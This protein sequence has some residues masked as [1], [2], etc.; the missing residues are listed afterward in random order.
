[1]RIKTVAM[2]AVFALLFGVSV[3][4]YV[5]LG[6]L[7]SLQINLAE[8]GPT[9]AIAA[10]SL[11][12]S[13][14]AE[15]KLGHVEAADPPDVMAFGTHQIKYLGADAFGEIGGKPGA[16]FNFW[17]GSMS[18]R[19]TRDVLFHLESI[20]QLP[21]R[22]LLISIVNPHFNN[23]VGT[24]NATADLPMDMIIA[25]TLTFEDRSQALAR[26]IGTAVKKLDDMFSYSNLLVGLLRSSRFVRTVDVNACRS[27]DGPTPPEATD[28]VERLMFKLPRTIQI[29]IGLPVDHLYCEESVLHTAIKSD[30]SYVLPRTYSPTR[31]AAIEER[32]EALTPDDVEKIAAAIED[33]RTIARRNGLSLAFFVAPVYETA[34][35]SETRRVLAD[36]LALAGAD[37]IIDDQH[38][39][40]DARY[41]IDYKHPSPAYYQTL[42]QRVA[43]RGLFSAP[44]EPSEKALMN[45]SNQ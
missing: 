2:I 40:N 4:A 37:D 8:L 22:A 30:G 41:F 17:H 1:M 13:Q 34:R 15:L 11:N 38:G 24:V 3:G 23:G 26:L 39:F 10:T 16:F 9:E 33:I 29:A 25:G 36:G 31:D 12:A 45:G 35:N 19:T 27:S 18:L 14:F 28:V 43:A 44:T 42:V 7:R 6:E 21:T 32:S 5:R 20:G